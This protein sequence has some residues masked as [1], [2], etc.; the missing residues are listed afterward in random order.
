MSWSVDGIAILLAGVLF[1]VVVTGGLMSIVPLTRT[2]LVAFAAAG[3]V[4]VGTALALAW[5]DQVQYPPLSW[6]LVLL[7]LGIIGV[8]SKDAITARRV[9]AL[10]ERTAAIVRPDDGQ[11]PQLPHSSVPQVSKDARERELAA[12]PHSTPEQ[13]SRLVVERPDLRPQLARNPSTPPA[14]I[15][16]LAS[17]DTPEIAAA[18]ESRKNLATSA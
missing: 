7:P 15:A 8:L 9:T 10:P 14:V 17:L 3:A 2:S 6:V 1:L 12:S 11:H 18:L 5:V 13:L 4:C 16:W